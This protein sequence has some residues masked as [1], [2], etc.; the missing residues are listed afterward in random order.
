MADAAEK[1]A[2][3]GG[4]WRDTPESRYWLAIETHRVAVAE[5]THGLDKRQARRVRRRMGRP[6]VTPPGE[7][8]A[9]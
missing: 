9:S 1:D 6:T 8:Q 7:G 2:A 4:W 5:A 3:L